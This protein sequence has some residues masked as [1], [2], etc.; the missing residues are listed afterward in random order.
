MKGCAGEVKSLTTSGNVQVPALLYRSS[1]I[2]PLE[3]VRGLAACAVVA[4]HYFT[5]YA[6]GFVDCIVGTP[7]VFLLNG[8]AAVVLFFVLSGFV[9]SLRPLQNG[10]A[11]LAGFKRWPRLAGPVVLSSLAY[12]A[13]AFWLFPPPAIVLA[14]LPD[15]PPVILWGT[16]LDCGHVLDVLWEAAAR[17]FWTGTAIH[18]DVLWSM[19]W[20]FMGSLLV[21]AL[22]A[23]V[24]A[25]PIW[26]VVIGLLAGTA[27]REPYLWCFLAGFLGA[28]LH[29]SGWVP[30]MSGR[31]ATMCFCLTTLLFSIPP[32]PQTVEVVAAY[33]LGA[34]LILAIALYHAPSQ[35]VLTGTAFALLGRMSFAIYLMHPFVLFSFTAWACV[36]MRTGVLHWW[37]YFPLFFVTCGIVATVALPVTRFDEWWVRAINRAF[38]PWTTVLPMAATGQRTDTVKETTFG[39]NAA[40]S[41]G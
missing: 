7:L 5:N 33:T 12:I 31:L 3:A 38:R 28:Y 16:H 13:G 29:Q 27:L 39:T 24:Q 32:E 6:P 19:H 26:A 23:A 34:V 2:Q 11:I 21:L 37:V 15:Y 9:L 1:K 36:W 18:N 22:A 20:E 25:R 41:A 10:G 35:R 17:T 4:G 40:K 30:T 14:T 8:K